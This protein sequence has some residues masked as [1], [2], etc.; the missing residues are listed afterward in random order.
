MKT[1]F[2]LLLLTLLYIPDAHAQVFSAQRLTNPFGIERAA[3]HH[4]L[5]FADLDADGDQDILTIDASGELP[6]LFLENTGT[7]QTPAFAAPVQN[8]FGLQPRGE[9]TT[10]SILDLNGDGVLDLMVGSSIGFLYYENT[11]SPEAPAFAVPVINPFG[12]T[13]PTTTAYLQITFGDVHNDG[14]ADVLAAAFDNKLFFYRNEGTPAEPAFA[15]AVSAPFGYQAPADA[16]LL[17]PALE[18][19]D[20]DGLLDLMIGYNPGKVAFYHNT[21]TRETPAF[22]APLANAFGLNLSSFPTWAMPVFVDMDEDGDRDLFICSFPH[23]YYYE[24]LSITTGTASPAA[25]PLAIY[26]NPAADFVTIQLPDAVSPGAAATV[27]L[28][29]VAGR[30]IRQERITARTQ[31]DLPLKGLPAG[32]YSLSLLTADATVYQSRLLIK[33]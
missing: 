8:P 30:L 10:I 7:P 4:R 16:I 3:T 9:Q 29:D 13:R 26:P 22:A 2:S 17:A 12:L 11:G 31:T 20:K 32:C 18:D 21:G 15:A 6:F 1:T 33:R 25:L 27:R 23:V 19:V 14:D 24:N 5:A 28:V